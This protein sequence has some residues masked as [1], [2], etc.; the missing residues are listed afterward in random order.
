[1]GMMDFIKRGG[2]ALPDDGSHDCTYPSFIQ[3]V[4]AA[5]SHLSWP[6][7][8]SF[9]VSR[10]FFSLSS[11]P[12]F[13]F[14][15]IFPLG[16]VFK[17]GLMGEECYG[18]AFKLSFLGCILALVLSVLAGVRREKMSKERRGAM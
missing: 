6:L 2:V 15:H 5:N 18:L 10:P 17:I 1:M 8:S 12:L 9:L 14:I 13:H 4:L 16:S 7:L 3:N 11:I